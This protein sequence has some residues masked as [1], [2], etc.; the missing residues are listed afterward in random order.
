MVRCGGMARSNDMDGRDIVKKYFEFIR[1]QPCCVCNG[2]NWNEQTGEWANTVSHVQRR[3]ST[4]RNEHYN[5]VVPMCTSKGCHQRYE[6]ESKELRERFRELAIQL[7]N[8]YFSLYPDQKPIMSILLK[9]A[10]R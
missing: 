2:G 10:V 6:L 1:S 8:E 5:C 4:R 7:T 3:G 9:Y